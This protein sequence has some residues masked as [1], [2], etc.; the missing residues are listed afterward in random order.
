MDLF[1]LLRALASLGFVLA[2]IGG[3]FWLLKRTGLRIAGAPVG[4]KRLAVVEVRALDT[5]RRLVL[6]RR[7]DQEH[8]L[9][10]GATGETVVETGIAPAVK[11]EA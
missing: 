6:I 2:L 11:Q 5:R 3:G 1:E 8:L 10:L 7:D 9:L 4:G